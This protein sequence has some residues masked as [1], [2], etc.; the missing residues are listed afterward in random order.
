MEAATGL[1]IKKTVT[2]LL[3]P[4][5]F[6]TALIIQTPAGKST[7]LY[8]LQQPPRQI[9]LNTARSILFRIIRTSLFETF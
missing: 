5:S 2:I 1:H 8:L 4:I 7:I 3:S 6:S 9:L